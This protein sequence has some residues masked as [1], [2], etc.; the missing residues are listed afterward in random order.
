MGLCERV[1]GADSAAMAAALGNLGIVLR[2]LGRLDEA[3]G[4]EES[5]LSIFEQALPANHPYIAQACGNLAG[6]LEALGESERA[7]EL[8]ARAEAI[9]GA[10]G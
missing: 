8:R 4:A 9:R 1:D 10:A 2:T 7:A 6:T 3:R 5:M